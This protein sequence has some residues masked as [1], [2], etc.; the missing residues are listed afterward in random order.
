[1]RQRGAAGRN[2][3]GPAK[4]G[5]QLVK[6]SLHEAPCTLSLHFIKLMLL[7]LLLLVSISTNTM[8]G[9]YTQFRI[10]VKTS[11]GR[12][13]LR[14]NLNRILF[15]REE[16]QISESGSSIATIQKED[17]RAQHITKVMN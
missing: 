2:P 6:S 9:L 17:T 16:V 13:I 5:R 11:S 15:E 7:L 14:R 8:H 12:L 3:P 4:W 10:T 1:L